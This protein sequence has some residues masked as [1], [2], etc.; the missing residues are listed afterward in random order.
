MT[1][2]STARERA[3]PAAAAGQGFPASCSQVE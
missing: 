2:Q 3:G 1:E